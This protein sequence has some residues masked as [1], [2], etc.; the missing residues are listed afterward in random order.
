MKNDSP[1]SGR[2]PLCSESESFVA[3]TIP[4]ARLIAEWQRGFDIDIRESLRHYSEILLHECRAC[5]LRYFSPSDIA[6]NGRLYEQLER[7]PGYYMPWKW[8]HDAAARRLCSGDHVLEIGCGEGSFV[9]RLRDEMGLDAHGIEL[10]ESSVA[11]ARKMGIPVAV[12]NV[13]DMAA[14][15]PASYDVVCAFQV[16]EHVPNPREFLRA[17]IT[18]LRP[19]GR[20]LMC[21]PNHDSFL[22]YQWNLLNM[23]PHHMTQWSASTFRALQRIF[24]VRLM[25]TE[26]EPLASYH[27]KGF[28]TT[29]ARHYGRHSFLNRLVWNPVTRFAVRGVMQ[30]GVRRWMRGQSL[31]AELCQESCSALAAA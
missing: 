12:G 19:G 25:K 31:F 29:Y 17:A 28:V 20:L 21:V 10:N 14:D 11:T 24:P 22:R 2:C 5:T 4:A 15:S 3:E 9:Q 26:H 13:L 6:G 18:L 30:A 23:P 1:S 8:E 7:V 16:L 27:V